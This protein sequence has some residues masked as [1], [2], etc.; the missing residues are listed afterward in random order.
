M[1]GSMAEDPFNTLLN[2]LGEM[3]KLVEDA[4]S[5]LSGPLDPS[6]EKK[7]ELAEKAVQRFQEIADEEI[8]KEGKEPTSAIEILEKSP[9]IY[10]EREKKILERCRDLGTN[11]VLLRLGIK[12]AMEDGKKPKQREVGKNTKKTIQKRRNKFKG[13]DGSQWNRL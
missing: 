13:M 10:T 11:A 2:Q 7:L 9:P 12:K 4:K 8:R 6:I 5:P 1:R 3:L